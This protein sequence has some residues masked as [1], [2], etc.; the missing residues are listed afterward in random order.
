MI[1][2]WMPFVMSLM[3]IS[4]C[5]RISYWSDHPEGIVYSDYKTYQMDDQ[6]SDYD[7]GVNPI[8]QIRIKNAL[9]IE[10]RSMGMTPSDDPDLNVKFFVKNETKYFYENCVEEY[11]RYTGGDQCIEKVH[12]YQEG[13]LVIDF[14]D[15]RRNLAVWHA[16][17][18]GEAWDSIDN[19][20]PVIKRMVRDLM[21]EYR[22]LGKAESF[23]S[24]E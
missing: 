21:K 20:D 15:V 1:Y 9:E 23:A 14:F 19:P 18:R 17:A 12:S 16:G 3:I 11:D 10:L 8:N 4:S 24:V 5:S 6:C 7:P 22:N 2:R 13:T